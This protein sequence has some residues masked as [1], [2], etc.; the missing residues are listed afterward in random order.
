MYGS[1]REGDVN[2]FVVHCMVTINKTKIQRWDMHP[3]NY[4][5]VWALGWFV[6]DRMVGLIVFLVLLK[7]IYFRYSIMLSD[8]TID[9]HK[10]L[11]RQKDDNHKNYW[12]LIFNMDVR[13]NLRTSILTNTGVPKLA[14]GQTLQWPQCLKCLAFVWFEL[15]KSWWNQI[16]I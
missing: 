7:C 14:T 6:I 1:Q 3:P 8:T 12:F 16:I 5:K 10:T 11:S 15:P 13:V 4:H 2:V 9:Y